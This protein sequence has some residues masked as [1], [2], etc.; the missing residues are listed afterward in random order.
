K[1]GTIA[2]HKA[3]YGVLSVE[4]AYDTPTT[5]AS[6]FQSADKTTDIALIGFPGADVSTATKDALAKLHA[7]MSQPPSGARLYFTGD[8]PIQ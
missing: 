1:L 4:D 7:V 8:A 5:V 6:S 2:Q 3:Q